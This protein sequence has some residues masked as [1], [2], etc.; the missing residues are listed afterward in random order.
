MKVSETMTTYVKTVWFGPINGGKIVPP[1]NVDPFIN[2]LL[3]KIQAQ[4]GK[5]LDV[6]MALELLAE[7]DQIQAYLI[8]YDGP[9]AAV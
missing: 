9:Q 1:E 7:G 4:G 3:E 6:K 8:I 2:E 5:I